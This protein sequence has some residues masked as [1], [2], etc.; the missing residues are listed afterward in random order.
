MTCDGCD[1]GRVSSVD[2]IIHRVHTSHGVLHLVHFSLQMWHP[3]SDSTSGLISSFNTIHAS[4]STL[5]MFLNASLSTLSID[6]SSQLLVFLRQVC[7]CNFHKLQLL[8]DGQRCWC[9]CTIWMTKDISTLLM[10]WTCGHQSS[11]N[12]TAFLS[13]KVSLPLHR[14]HQ[15]MMYKNQQAE[16][17]GLQ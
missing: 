9:W 8:L 15:L 16:C 14:W 7:H 11:P 17:F 2:E 12:H 1:E 5:F 13:W 3:S 6:F 10:F 4:L